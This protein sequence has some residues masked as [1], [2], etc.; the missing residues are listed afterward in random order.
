[1]Y[2]P[3]TTLCATMEAEK[4]KLVEASGKDQLTSDSIEHLNNVRSVYQEILPLKFFLHN[5]SKS[6]CTKPFQKFDTSSSFSRE[7]EI[8]S[9]KLESPYKRLNQ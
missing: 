4:T 1:M 5:P 3:L 9:Q 2:G 6:N 7:T 8:F